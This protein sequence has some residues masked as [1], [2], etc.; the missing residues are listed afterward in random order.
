MIRLF[1]FVFYSLVFR[2]PAEMS[3]QEG[4][5]GIKGLNRKSYDIPDC[6]VCLEEL[7]SDLVCAPCGHVFH[8]MCLYQTLESNSACPCDRIRMTRSSVIS[9]R[10]NLKC[11]SEAEEQIQAFYNSLAAEEKQNVVSILNKYET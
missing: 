3:E 11:N 5:T 6:P 8:A 2:I 7:V 1:S 9:M 10:F 4:A